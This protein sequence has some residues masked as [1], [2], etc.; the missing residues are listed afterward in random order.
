MINEGNVLFDDILNIFYDYDH[1]GKG[2]LSKKI[3]LCLHFMGYSFQLAAR[4]LF[5]CTIR[6]RI[7]HTLGKGPLSKKRNRLPPLHG[8]FFSVSSKGS[9]YMHQTTEKNTLIFITP[10]VEHWWELEIAQ[11]VHYERTIQ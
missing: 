5:I 4:D 7:S 1:L 8:L 11:Q 9:F 3:N 6:N 10:V 2:S